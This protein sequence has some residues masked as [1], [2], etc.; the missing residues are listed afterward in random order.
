MTPTNNKPEA[1]AGHV[2]SQAR[3]AAIQALYQME[4]AEA[5]A[6]GVIAEFRQHRFGG[7]A[8]GSLSEVDEGHFINLVRGVVV[9]Q[10]EI[11][12]AIHKALA[13]GWT[14]AR[15]D[16]ILRALL[17]SAVFELVERKDVPARVVLDE[18]IQLAHDFFEGEEPRFVNGILDRLAKQLRPDEWAD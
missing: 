18:Y 1:P 8:E 14:L 11:D 2:R 10:V 6:E 9:R 7:A 5:D 4:I 12:R 15:I 13:T 3:L 17:R 16:S